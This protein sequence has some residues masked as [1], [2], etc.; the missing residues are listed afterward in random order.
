MID[1]SRAQ[2]SR[3]VRILTRHPPESN[4]CAKAARALLPIA[5]EVDGAAQA[6]VIE[7]QDAIYVQPKNVTSR[8]LHHVTVSA[9]K[10]YVDA[11]TGPDGHEQATYLEHFF[12]HPEHHVTRPVEPD[13]WDAL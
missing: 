4:R 11:L 10:H 6:L 3:V 2:K 9:A 5:Q 1:W 7:A 12:N 13:E 8:W